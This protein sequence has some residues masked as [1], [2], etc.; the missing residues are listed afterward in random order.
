MAITTDITNS[1]RSRSVIRIVNTAAN[2]NTIITLGSLS[3]NSAL[4]TVTHAAITQVIATSNT[5]RWKIY[6]GNDASG[7]LIMTVGDGADFPLSQ[8]DIA[9]ANTP[10]ANIYVTNTGSDGTLIL[11]VTKTAT[12]STG[13]TGY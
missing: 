13:L 2:D 7:V 10:T 1:L 3:A 9:I 11:Q 8:Y 12:Y 4:E 6:R 5:G